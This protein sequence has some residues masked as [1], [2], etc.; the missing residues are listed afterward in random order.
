MV[1]VNC[2][3]EFSFDEM[4]YRNNALLQ[5]QC[6]EL[7]KATEVIMSGIKT[8]SPGTIRCEKKDF[9]FKLVVRIKHNGD[10]VAEV[11]Y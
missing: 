3:G 10:A 1:Y 2:L 4:T 7:L 6:N 9:T 8:L 5:T 11:L